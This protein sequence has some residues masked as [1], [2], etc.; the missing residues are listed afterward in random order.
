MS[1]RKHRG[2]TYRPWAFTEH[3]ALMAA[4]ILRSP[5]AREMSIFIIRAFLRMREEVA[6]NAAI[7]KRLAE[8]DHAL[9]LH[10]SALHDL[11]LKLLPLLTPPPDPPKP[12]IGFHPGNR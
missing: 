6:S 3:G 8:I 5:R 7:L 10:D 4:N 11:Y 12:R 2:A 1:S 9:L